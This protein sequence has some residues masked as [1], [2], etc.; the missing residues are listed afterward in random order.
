MSLLMLAGVMPA[1]VSAARPPGA[2]RRLDAKYKIDPKL[3]AE[4]LKLRDSVNR[5]IMV[6]VELTRPSVG[7]SIAARVDAGEQ[8]SE[9][10]RSVLRTPL[11]QDQAVV[12][13]AIQRVNGKVHAAFT[14]TVNGFRATVPAGSVDTLARETG[15]KAV[16]LVGKAI[17][18]N[19]NTARYVRAPQTWKSTGFTGQGVK[20]AVIDTGVNYYHKDFGGLGEPANTTDNPAIIEPGT[21][22]TAKVVGGWDF[23]GD[24]YDADTV[25]NP[26]PDPD[27]KDCNGHGTHVAGTAAGQ[28]VKDDGSTYTGPYNPTALNNTNWNVAP[29]MAPRASILA[30]KVFGCDGGT[31]V[32]LDAIE[33]AVRDGAQVINMSLGLEYG[34]GGRVEEI[35]VDNAVKAGVTVV[36]SIGNYGPSAYVGGSPG[37]SKGAIAV[38]ALDANPGFPSAWIDMP[39]GADIRGINANGNT[40]GM[41]VTGNLNHF[42]DNPGTPCDSDTGLG[43]EESGTHADSYTYNAYVV[44]EIPVV[45]RGNGARVDRAIEGDNQ[46]APA[47]IMVNN[48]AGFPPFEGPIAGADIPFIGVSSTDEARFHTDDGGSATISQAPDL[49]NPGYRSYSNFTSGGFRRV[50]QL[51]KPDVI[52][53]GVSVFSADADNVEGAI[54]ISGTSMASPA[55][56]GVAALVR[57]AFPGLNPRQV[58]SQIVNT[59]NPNKVD[60][61]DLRLVGAGVVDA[62]RATRSRVHITV[63]NMQDPGDDQMQASLAFGME[64]LTRQTSGTALSSSRSFRIWNRGSSAVTYKITNNFATPAMGLS[65]QVTPSTV[66]VGAGSSALVTAKISMSNAA[67]GNLSK[68]AP[69]HG[70]VLRFDPV[71]GTPYLPLEYIGGRL[72][73]KPTVVK[74]GVMALRVPW[75]VVPRGTSHIFGSL[76]AFSYA[77]DDA[78][79]TLTV[80]NGAGSVHSGYADIFQWGLQDPREGYDGMDIRAAG[81]QT[82]PPEICD[83]SVHSPDVCLNVA[84]NNWTRFSNASEN[85]YIVEIDTDDDEDVDYEIYGVDA[86]VLL[87]ALEG[88]FVSAVYDVDADEFTFFYLGTAP[89]NSSTLMLPFLASD[90]GLSS[91]GDQ[92]FDYFAYGLDFW[93][94]DGDPAVPVFHQDL[95]MTGSNPGAADCWVDGTCPANYNAF[96]PVFSNGQFEELA[97]N[98]TKTIPLT[99]DATRYDPERGMKGWLLVSL[100]DPSGERQADMI[101]PTNL[102]PLPSS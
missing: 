1:S 37:T 89:T 14:D 77:G 82:L 44:G 30:Y 42:V 40:N 19:E 80:R 36:T 66:T 33:R 101:L 92:D 60:Q 15:V 38:A 53:P 93:D 35:A 4:L 31:Y 68:A 98:Q 10:Q 9:A 46:G 21:F 63:P 65:V 25:P 17:I 78:N 41:P 90:I 16:H 51:L 87:G 6:F 47:V 24:A 99:V 34:N 71:H 49:A 11:R 58:K 8:V 27:P 26:T 76:G 97:P 94:D 22:P 67:A 3:A 64:E 57:Q 28:G 69:F 85:L 88:V 54:G 18:N 13:R 72:L 83:S 52:A 23:V 96:N 81:V 39:T 55:V 73:V 20:L 86:A 2:D 29:G 70:P 74:P 48:S 32:V 5:P 43:C 95:A 56:A 61:E 12:Q 75:A 45:H 62:L 84:I 100:D 91:S 79:T 50:D 59:A 102:Q 7:A